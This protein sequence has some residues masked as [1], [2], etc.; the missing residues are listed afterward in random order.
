M[1]NSNPL[2]DPSDFDDQSFSANFIAAMDDYLMEAPDCDRDAFERQLMEIGEHNPRVYELLA[3]RVATFEQICKAS[4]SCL[5]SLSKTAEDAIPQNTP[6]NVNHAQRQLSWLAMSLV[7][8]SVALVTLQYCVSTLRNHRDGDA[9]IGLLASHW[10]EVPL[11]P[12]DGEVTLTLDSVV[13]ATAENRATDDQDDLDADDW[14][15]EAAR[16]F[17]NESQVGKA[18]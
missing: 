5:S 7:A 16:E 9:Q 10:I 12:A 18:G 11:D 4:K 2:G 8:A 15:L 6:S 17:F 14:M 13:E 3:A 1:K